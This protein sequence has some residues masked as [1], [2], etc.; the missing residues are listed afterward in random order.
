MSKII[1][2]KNTSAMFLATVLVAG[3]IGISS[4][5]AA[6]GQEYDYEENYDSY[7]PYKP[8]MRDDKSGSPISQS[9]NCDNSNNIEIG[10][11]QE[12]RTNTNEITNPNQNDGTTT[13][14]GQELTPEEALNGLAGNSND[15]GE[16]LL[17]IDRNIANVCFNNIDI[18]LTPRV[19]NQLVAGGDVGQGDVNTPVSPP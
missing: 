16:P 8:E 11:N 7:D 14:N 2:T 18:D 3:V 13:L 4:S 15:N 6:F 19:D 5:F 9:A 10:I 12:E 17:N 1:S